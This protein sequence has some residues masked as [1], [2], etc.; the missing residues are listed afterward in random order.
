MSAGLQPAPGDQAKVSVSVAVPPV[1]AF[2][3]FTEEIELWWRRGPRYRAAGS[4][5]IIHLEPGVGGRLFESFDDEGGPRVVQTGEVTCWEPPSRLV[6]R[7]RNVNFAP[8]EHTEVEVLFAAQRGGTLV[9]VIHRGW[10]TLRPDHPARHGLEVEA[11]V[12]MIGMWWGE[13]ASSLREHVE[14]VAAGDR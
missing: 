9:T 5:G 4:R 7:W 8:D 2:R 12:R 13:L 14:R 11:F 3:I 6:L 1:E 10:S